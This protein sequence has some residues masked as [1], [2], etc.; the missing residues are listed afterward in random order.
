MRPNDPARVVVGVSSTLAGYEALRYAVA[1]ARKSG[2]ALVAVRAYRCPSSGYSAEWHDAIRDDAAAAAKRAFD[3]ALGGLPRDI[4][5][6]VRVAEGAVGWVLAE[7]AKMPADLLVIG[8]SGGRLSGGRVAKYCAR[9]AACPVVIVPRPAMSRS[10]SAAKMGRDL[11][12]EAQRF[13]DT[14]AEHKRAA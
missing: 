6:Q 2:M 11:A 4:E 7:S 12:S 10:S 14:P 9:H 8:G 3:E 5:A 1:V 13:L